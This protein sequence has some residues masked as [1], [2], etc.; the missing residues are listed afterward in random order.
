MNEQKTRKPQ[1][2]EQL[3]NL[4][5]WKPGE[6]G[7]PSGRPKS[8]VLSDAYRRLLE[9]PFPNDPQG[10]THAELIALGQ[11]RE[12]IKGKTPAAAEIADRTEGKARQAVELSGPGGSAIPL[13]IPELDRRIADLLARAGFVAPSSGAES[14]TLPTPAAE[15]TPSATGDPQ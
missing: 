11:V 6:S 8:K 10:R 7:N 3:A 15:G 12:A 13:S 5:P 4:K 1:S 14:G 9:E 2:P